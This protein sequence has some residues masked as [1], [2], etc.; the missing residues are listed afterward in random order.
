MYIGKPL[1]KVNSQGVSLGLGRIS[2]FLLMGIRLKKLCCGLGVFPSSF[3]YKK[4][5][6]SLCLLQ[7]LRTDG[8][9]ALATTGGT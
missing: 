7:V 8:I 4:V 3:R 9:E 5:V 2:Y 6:E 1:G